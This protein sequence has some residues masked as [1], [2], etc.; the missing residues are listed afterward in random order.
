MS[1]TTNGDSQDKETRELRSRPHSSTSST[2]SNLEEQREEARRANPN[3]LSRIHT[4][5]SV[6]QAE[7]DFA[8]LQRE[9]SGISRASRAAASHHRRKDETDVEKGKD[10][11]AESPTSEDEP[12][13]LESYLRGGL[14]AEQAAGIRPKHIGVYWNG[15]TVKGMGGLTNY[16]KT[17]PDAVVDFFDV[18]RPLLGLLGHGMK[19]TEATLLDGFKGVCNPGEMIL[20][21]GKPGERNIPHVFFV[22]AAA[23]W[24]SHDIHDMIHSANFRTERRW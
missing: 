23:I 10:A 7:A 3:G 22:A 8:G 24:Q 19:G 1:E 2:I 14:A 16:V 5:V 13:D 15:L 12:F 18:V 21:L 11:F 4:G 20:V 9:L 17:F 6:E